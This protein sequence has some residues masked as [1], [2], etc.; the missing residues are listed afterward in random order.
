MLNIYQKRI[1]WVSPTPLWSL[2]VLV[3]PTPGAP[4]TQ[5]ELVLSVADYKT[6][7]TSCLPHSQPTCRVLRLSRSENTPIS[8]SHSSPLLQCIFKSMRKST[9]SNCPLMVRL[10]LASSD[11]SLIYF[12]AIPI[13]SPAFPNKNCPSF[14]YI[15]PSLYSLSRLRSAFINI[16]N[17]AF[18]PLPTHMDHF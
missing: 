16:I 13:A 15:S 9:I 14:S 7:W 4:T 6:S 18:K 12:T 3:L 8:L 17:L 2:Q 11:S 10:T 1:I 5:L